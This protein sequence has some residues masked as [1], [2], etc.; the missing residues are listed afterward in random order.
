MN[1]FITGGT[2][3]IGLELTHLYLDEGHRIGIC[4]G[5]KEMYEKAFPE[6]IANLHF[7]ELDV[8]DRSATKHVISQFAEGS[9]DLVIASAGINYGKPDIDNLIDHEI[10]QKI[11]A[12]NLNGVLHTFE[13]ALQIMLPNKS[14]HLVAM[15][16]GSG[17]AGFPQAP[18]YCASKAAVITYCESLAT[19]L[20]PE[21]IRIT[22]VAPGYVDTPLPRATNPDFEKFPWVLSAKEAAKRIKR[23]IEKKKELFIFPFPIYISTYIMHRMPR[24][25]FRSLFRRKIASSAGSK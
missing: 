1:I 24:W 16:S 11:F 17:F 3:G 18:A 5:P 15:A 23:A 19:R 6:P 2:S 22:T 9:L 10:E 14:G 20:Y 4:G 21:G 25:I 12:V 8:T 13:A 7:Y